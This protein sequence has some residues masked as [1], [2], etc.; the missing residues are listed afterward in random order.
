M[1]KQTNSESKKIMIKVANQ[2]RNESP[3]YK[4]GL[5]VIHHNKVVGWTCDTRSTRGWLPGCV[6]VAINGDCYIAKGGDELVG[7]DRWDKWLQEK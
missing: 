5:V 1:S 7:A 3:S 2:W 4:G 6:A